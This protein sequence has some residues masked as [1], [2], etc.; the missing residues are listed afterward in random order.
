MQG[1]KKFQT[2]YI[3]IKPTITLPIQHMRSSTHFFEIRSSSHNKLKIYHKSKDK[4]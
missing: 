2:P 3:I 4:V 1:L